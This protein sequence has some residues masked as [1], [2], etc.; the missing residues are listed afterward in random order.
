MDG[1]RADAHFARRADHAQRD[2]A[3]VGHKDLVEHARLTR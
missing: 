2:L 1:D 3:A